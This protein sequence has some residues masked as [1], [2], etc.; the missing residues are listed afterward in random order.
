MTDRLILFAAQGFGSGRIPFAPGTFGS[1]VGLIWLACLIWPGRLELF[2]IG[3]LSST[4]A[5][6]WICGR[7]EKI[8]GQTD[9]GSIVLDEII[10]VPLCFLGLII[11][12]R[13]SHD[14]FPNLETFF[15]P[16]NW[17]RTGIVFGLFRFFDVVKP[18][19]VRQLQRLPGGWGVTI[20]DVAAALYVNLVQIPFFL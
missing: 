14:V 4:L 5:A 11:S 19:P 9:P 15:H 1:V 8:L 3:L 16:R 12:H 7:A 2:L 17:L 6:I 18:P 20:D 13:L 10:A